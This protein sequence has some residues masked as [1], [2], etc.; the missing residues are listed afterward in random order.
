[1]LNTWRILSTFY[2][3]P[4]VLQKLPAE[5]YNENGTDTK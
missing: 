3:I 2:S 1:M 4:E 5:E